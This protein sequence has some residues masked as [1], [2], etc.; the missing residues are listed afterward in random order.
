MQQSRCGNVKADTW[1]HV[2][3]VWTSGQAPRVY[4]NGAD[5]TTSPDEYADA[6]SRRPRMF[7]PG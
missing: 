6:E 3:G 4:V 1:Y 7:K 5:Q 2:V